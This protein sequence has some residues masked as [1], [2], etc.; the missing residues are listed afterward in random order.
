MIHS[1]SAGDGRT[2]N[3]LQK[4]SCPGALRSTPREETQRRSGLQGRRFLR[5]AERFVCQRIDGRCGVVRTKG[6]DANAAQSEQ[7]RTVM[8]IAGSST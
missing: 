3:I 6:N 4:S 8:I 7:A 2:Y 5:V 1:H